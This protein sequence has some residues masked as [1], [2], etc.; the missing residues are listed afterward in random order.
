MLGMK[1]QGAERKWG[2]RHQ[3]YECSG[4]NSVLGARKHPETKMG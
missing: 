1:I 2:L 4:Q 3:K